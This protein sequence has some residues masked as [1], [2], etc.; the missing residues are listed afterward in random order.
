MM[1]FTIIE[2]PEEDINPNDSTCIM[3]AFKYMVEDE[4]GAR[5]FGSNTMEECV[6]YI[7][8]HNNY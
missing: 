2:I 7:D 6:N 3:N 8:M 5:W 4:N 1:N